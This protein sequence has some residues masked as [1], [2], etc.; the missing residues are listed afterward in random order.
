MKKSIITLI[1]ATAV[2]LTSCS[3]GGKTYYSNYQ[4]PVPQ[5]QL[6]TRVTTI[7][8]RV[9]TRVVPGFDAGWFVHYEFNC[10]MLPGERYTVLGGLDTDGMRY[11]ESG[12]CNGSAKVP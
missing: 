8:F 3:W 12:R 6:D 7:P 9:W 10:W 2:L 1:I 11:I 5:S 4:V